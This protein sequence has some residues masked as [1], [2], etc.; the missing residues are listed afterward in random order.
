MWQ[1]L[2]CYDTGFIS[3]YY[4]SHLQNLGFCFAEKLQFCYHLTYLNMGPELFH[5][6]SVNVFIIFFAYKRKICS[7]WI[8]TPCLTTVT[9]IKLSTG[10]SSE[11]RKRKRCSLRLSF[12]KQVL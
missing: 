5:K 3:S 9:G 6:I 4:V 1:S 2:M 10:P 11:K 8:F 12:F 7:N